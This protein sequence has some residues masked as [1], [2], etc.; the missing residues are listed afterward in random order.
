MK[1]LVL[2]NNKSARESLCKL[3]RAYYSNLIPSV[4][5]RDLIYAFSKL[6]EYDKHAFESEMTKRLDAI[7]QALRGIGNTIIDPKD[8]D[9]PYAE[10]L[11]KRIAEAEQVKYNMEKKLM[12]TECELKI[13]RSRVENE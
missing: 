9:S 2:K 11:K 6:L 3:M 4:K 12:E 1:R 5:F 8:I 7:E 13:L 10:D